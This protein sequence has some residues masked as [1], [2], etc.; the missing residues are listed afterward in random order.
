[1][2]ALIAGHRS[3]RHFLRIPQ[4]QI[5]LSSTDNI[6][7]SSL[8]LTIENKKGFIKQ[9]ETDSYSLGV[10]SMQSLEVGSLS[11]AL[12]DK[13]VH[14]SFA[15]EAN[16]R[17]EDLN[18]ILGMKRMNLDSLVNVTILV[19]DDMHVPLAMDVLN[20]FASEKKCFAGIKR[21][22]LNTAKWMGPG[23]VSFQ[24]TAVAEYT[25]CSNC[26]GPHTMDQC[27]HN[28]K[29]NKFP[30][31]Y[32]KLREDP[33]WFESMQ[34]R[35]GEQGHDYVL[36]GPIQIMPSERARIHRLI[37]KRVMHKLG[38]AWGKADVAKKMLEERGV[39]IFDS[40]RTYRVMPRNPG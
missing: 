28:K 3:A 29:N 39:K 24:A 5:R 7:S 4:K 14:D 30:I 1:M 23:Q 33:K 15:S 13:R 18:N 40:D 10:H 8:S 19:K 22:T 31:N 11:L 37:S 35:F 6:H 26:G 25:K 27:P 12:M 32:K 38:K 36:E 34:L 16:Q 21:P 9:N 2:N 20:D 17:L